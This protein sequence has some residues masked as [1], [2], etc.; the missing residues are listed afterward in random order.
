[1]DDITSILLSK[2]LLKK[3]LMKSHGQS[4]GLVASR[5]RSVERSRNGGDLSSSCRRKSKGL[6][7]SRS[8]NKGIQC[9][10]CKE[11]GY[12]KWDC[13]K[14][15]RKRDKQDDDN[16]GDNYSA[17]SVAVA[18]G[19]SVVSGELLVVIADN[20]SIGQCTSSTLTDC[21]M[22]FNTDVRHVVGLK[23]NLISFKALDR[24]GY[25]FVTQSYQIKVFRGSLCV[26]KAHT[27]RDTYDIYFL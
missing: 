19:D 9:R 23:K 22:S 27:T 1:M 2:D 3:S 11:F 14:L 6:S 5:G 10:Y 17:A 15:K 13:P 24:K 21:D 8:G 16:N 4:E 25:K 20:S 18:D 7:K 12:F 26:M